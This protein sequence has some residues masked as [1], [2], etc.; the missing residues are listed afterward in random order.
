MVMFIIL[1][2]LPNIEVWNIEEGIELKRIKK[3]EDGKHVYQ[4]VKKYS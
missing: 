2:H 3:Q 4:I 1:C